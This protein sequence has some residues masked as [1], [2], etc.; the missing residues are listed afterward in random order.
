MSV[1]SGHICKVAIGLVKVLRLTKW[2]LPGMKHKMVDSSEFEDQWDTFKYGRTE[3]GTAEFSGWLDTEDDTGQEILRAAMVTTVRTDVND[4]RFYYGEAVSS[5]MHLIAGATAKPMELTFGDA[6]ANSGLVP[7]SFKL[8]VSNGCFEEVL[9]YHTG[10]TVSFTHNTGAQN[11][12]IQK[13]GGIPFGSLGFAADQ[14]LIIEGSTLNNLAL[15]I[16][17]VA[18]DVLTIHEDTLTTEIAGD[19]V[20]LIGMAAAP[21]YV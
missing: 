2:S 9:A 7:C 21:I 1:K 4:L 14:I 19:S 8:Q 6:D 16:H 18:N 13:T 15:T 10:I 3:G 20:S 17:T 12:T 11:D 5:F